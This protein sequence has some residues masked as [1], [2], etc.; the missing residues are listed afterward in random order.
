MSKQEELDFN[1]GETGN[2]F[3]DFM[4]ELESLQPEQT[5]D[6]VPPVNDNLS[7]GNTSD[8]VEDEN[9]EDDAEE[10]VINNEEE[11]DPDTNQ[12]D[13]DVDDVEYS[14]LA[15]T[16][17]LSEMGILD[18]LGEDELDDTPEALE[19][20][21]Q[22]T[23]INLVQHYKDSIPD[24]GKDF[25]NYIEKGGD[26]SKFFQSL[27]KPID[28]ETIDLSVEDNQKIVYKEYLKT[29]NWTNEEIDEELQD[30][31]DNLLLEKKAKMASKK[32]EVVHSQKRQNL[33]QQQEQEKQQQQQEYTNYV[34]QIKTTIESSNQLAGLTLTPSEKVEFEKYLL[35]QDKDGQTAYQ[36]DL[37]TDPIKTSLELAYLKYKKYDFTKAVT[38]AKTEETRRIRGLIKNTDKSVGRS[39]QIQNSNE[40]VLG[41]FRSI[42]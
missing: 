3:G 30:V 12:N 39:P 16:N 34:N 41:A 19:K 7:V 4:P 2:I 32:L 8:L 40:N 6:P 17:H 37:S 35:Q 36:K 42:M 14:Y 5:I 9:L 28:F 15:L 38:K 31:E 29:L 20:A 10:A 23:V 26:P 18:E 1:F 13:D 21:V 27:E 33:L 24:A 11:D 25:L 22:K